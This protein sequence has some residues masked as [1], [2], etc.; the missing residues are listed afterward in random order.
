M[1]V[2]CVYV[3]V[4]ADFYL[5]KT[6]KKNWSNCCLL[7]DREY[8]KFV[9]NSKH[10]KHWK[11]EDFLF[12]ASLVHDKRDIF[13]WPLPKLYP[14]LRVESLKSRVEI[15]KCE[16]K[17]TSS[18]SRVSSSILRVTSSNLRVTSSIRQ[19]TSSNPRVISS[20]ARVQEPFN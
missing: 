15:Q 2:L 17:S 11:A 20:K 16:F 8:W 7:K 19:V 6:P 13:D 12:F 10:M 14:P 1:C 18:N 9:K 5:R 3:A 4:M